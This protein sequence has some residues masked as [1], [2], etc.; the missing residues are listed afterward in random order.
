MAEQ[1]NNAPID[2]QGRDAMTDAARPLV[3][4]AWRGTRGTAPGSEEQQKDQQRSRRGTGLARAI[5]A[6][7]ARIVAFLRRLFTG[8]EPTENEGQRRGAAGSRPGPGRLLFRALRSAVARR[9]QR[10]Q[11]RQNRRVRRARNRLDRAERRLE[12]AGKRRSGSQEMLEQRR[13]GRGTSSR[14]GRKEAGRPTRR[15]ERGR[16]RNQRRV[17]VARGRKDRARVRLDR[18]ERRAS[19]GDRRTNGAERRQERGKRRVE[20]ARLRVGRAERRAERVQG[21][22][23][24]ANAR[25]KQAGEKN[26]ASVGRAARRSARSLGR[27]ERADRRAQKG[28][29]RAQNRIERAQQHLAKAEAKVGTAPFASPRDGTTGAPEPGAREQRTGGTGENGQERPRQNRESERSALSEK[30]LAV[31]GRERGRNTGHGPGQDSGRGMDHRRRDTD[32]R[33][34]TAS[35]L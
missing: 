26:R 23:D 34:D 29:E 16:Q 7:I 4:S 15:S 5:G 24:A 14:G 31:F 33:T 8:R 18:A 13:Q 28:V 9:P 25:M 20:R 21:K 35:K 27:A 22:Q 12:R 6:I 17:H 11:A 30:N 19:S 10:R 3:E 2:P 32:A 1:N